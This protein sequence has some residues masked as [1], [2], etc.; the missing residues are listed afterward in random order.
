MRT[1]ITNRRPRMPSS[2]KTCVQGPVLLLSLDN[3][4]TPPG[5]ISP[6]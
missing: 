2:Q 4:Q 1:A 6:T 3:E 5:I